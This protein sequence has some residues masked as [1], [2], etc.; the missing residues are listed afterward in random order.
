MIAIAFLFVR[1]LCDC[2]KP[3]QRCK[4]KS[5]SF[6]ISSTSCGSVRHADCIW[7]GS[8]ALYSSGSI[9][10][11]PI[12]RDR[13][14]P[15]R[16][17]CH[18]RRIAC[19]NCFAD[20]TLGGSRMRESRTYGSGRGAR[21]NSRPYREVRQP[22]ELQP[23]NFAHLAHGSSLCWHPDGQ[24]SGP[25]SAGRGT[26]PGRDHPGIVGDIISDRWARSFRNRGR[27]YPESWARSS[28][29]QH[30]LAATRDCI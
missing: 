25:E 20:W 15:A 27:R 1:M 5:W 22:N 3:R 28:R 2:F 21:G 19:G 23:K 9:G 30:G 29:N 17:A 11:V 4:Q 6:G 7:V 26:C 14:S 10:A 8:T 16:L 24:R 18:R 12:E 13:H